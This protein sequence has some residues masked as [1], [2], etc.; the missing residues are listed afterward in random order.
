MSTFIHDKYTRKA[1]QLV[2]EG[3]S[4]FITGKAGT[5]KTMLLREI[6]KEHASL[7]KDLLI[8]A[9]TGIA[10]KNAGGATL[11]STFRLPI[12][13][14]I[15]GHKLSDLFKQTEKEIAVIRQLRLL[16]I[17]EVSMV[18]CDLMD[19]LD[20]VLRRHRNSTEPFGGVQVVMFGD[21][22]QL[23]PVAETVDEE[24]LLKH[25]RSLYF[26]SSEV[27]SKMHLPM[28]ELMTI[29]RQHDG[30]FV[31]LLNNVRDG[32]L[33][34]SDERRLRAKY[35]KTF[36]PSAH[37]EYIRL[38]THR[39]A[40]RK[41]N[42]EKLESIRSS[43]RTYIA[44]KD[45][46]FPWHEYPTEEKLR[47]KVGARVMFV[48]NDTGEY[49]QYVNGTLGY[50]TQLS[51]D[52]IVVRTD[53]GRQ[54]EVGKASWDFYKYVINKQKKEIE[55]TVLGTFHQFPLQ[56]AWA[57]TIHK[58]QGQTFDRVV[59]DAGRAFAYG[60]VYVALSR[61][62]TLRGIVLSTPITKEIVMSD[63]LVEEYIQLVERIWPDDDRPDE[64]ALPSSSYDFIK[65]TGYTT[66]GHLF[67]APWDEMYYDAWESAD[68]F[69]YLDRLIEEDGEANRLCVCAFPEES[70]PFEV[71]SRRNYQSILSV[72]FIGGEACRIDIN[73]NGQ[74]RHF[75]FYGK[76]KPVNI[77]RDAVKPDIWDREPQLRTYSYSRNDEKITIHK[78]SPLSNSNPSEIDTYSDLGKLLLCCDCY[79]IL[80]ND[81]YYDV[82]VDD[83]T[84]TILQYDLNGR[85]VT[86]EA[87]IIAD[88][89]FQKNR[90]HANICAT[91]KEVPKTRK[92]RPLSPAV[93]SPSSTKSSKKSASSTS[94]SVELQI[95]S[96]LRTNGYMK[97][98][99][100]AKALSCTT[101]DVNRILHGSLSTRGLVDQYES[102]WTLR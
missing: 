76:E 43:E 27:I 95:I 37:S 62:R 87:R 55:R 59:I 1:M 20:E 52:K 67:K 41:H 80:R 10:A 50:V 18:R 60:Q 4:L 82:A 23:M 84:Y 90:D 83:G 69:F 44:W 85:A 51:D 32:I 13:I 70:L 17:D 54:I 89:W 9:P 30:D 38:T 101:K 75:N 31:S 39:I 46:I 7:K 49:R 97:A 19:M 71:L 47:L 81:S 5:G 22:K 93:P 64:A 25:Y 65:K 28:L 57:I 16:I 24:K 96:C 94:P 56:L 63:P 68:H 66:I 77:E 33:T 35:D 36:F 86:N 15:P 78:H 34:D 21:L 12:G 61:C 8:C 100:I 3:K 102:Y 98:K 26:F 58:S 72:D 73:D 48:A 2:R 6:V 99:E 40:A 29:H 74:V 91:Y 14:Y 88:K 79:K 42:L 11:H 92:P 53:D 45:G